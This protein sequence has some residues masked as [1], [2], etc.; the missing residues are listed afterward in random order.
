MSNMNNNKPHPGVS[1]EERIS[2][3]GLQRLEEHLK[4]GSRM[5]PSILKQW[6]KRYGDSARQLIKQHKQYTPDMD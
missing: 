1:R 2:K 6:I 4:N 5:K 3:E